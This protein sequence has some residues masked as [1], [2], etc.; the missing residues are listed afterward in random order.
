MIAGQPKLDLSYEHFY[1]DGAKDRFLI[2]S[3]T[4]QTELIGQYLEWITGKGVYYGI[5]DEADHQKAIELTNDEL[6][7]G[8]LKGALV[9]NVGARIIDPP[10]IS[11]SLAAFLTLATGSPIPIVAQ[12]IVSPAVRVS[13]ASYRSSKD[14]AF[15]YPIAT[16]LSAIPNLGT[17]AYIPELM[18]YNPQSAVLI[19]RLSTLTF[20]YSVGSNLNLKESWMKRVMEAGDS[21]YHS[22]TYPL[23]PPISPKVRRALT[24]VCGF[25][26]KYD[27]ILRHF[28]NQV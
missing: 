14:E 9:N 2:F 12:F 5:L 22:A 17:F 10:Y 28:I 8:C 11:T 23:R 19:G 13:Y 16:Q 1:G 25:L 18:F 21:A 24:G 6:V 20:T 3:D 7:M 4:Y 26:V 27:P 15:D